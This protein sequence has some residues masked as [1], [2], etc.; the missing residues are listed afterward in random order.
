ML[1]ALHGMMVDPHLGAEGGWDF[2]V[3]PYIR[4]PSAESRPPHAP[5][6]PWHGMAGVGCLRQALG[7]LLP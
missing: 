5:H 2:R 7:T 6:S 1:G 4:Q 3:I